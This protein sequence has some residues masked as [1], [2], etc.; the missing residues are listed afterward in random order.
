VGRRK[1]TT[2]VYIEPEQDELLKA[3]SERTGVPVAA[4]IRRGI[5][6]VLEQNRDVLPGQL[7]LFEPARKS[8]RKR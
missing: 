5:D 6:L 8:Q 1:V 3:L 2:T 4:Y 7:A